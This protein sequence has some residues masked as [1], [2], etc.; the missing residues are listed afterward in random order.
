ME[1]GTYAQGIEERG[2]FMGNISQPM[3]KY[4]EYWCLA[5]ILNF[6]LQVAAAMQPFAI[7]RLQ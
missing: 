4:R 1:V 3:L 5:N 7:G 6:I 2:S